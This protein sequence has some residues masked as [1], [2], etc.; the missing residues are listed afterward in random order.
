MHQVFTRQPCLEEGQ[1]AIVGVVM[2]QHDLESILTCEDED[3]EEDD[4][5]LV[6]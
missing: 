6:R 3:E 4:E 1:C 5:P 2:N